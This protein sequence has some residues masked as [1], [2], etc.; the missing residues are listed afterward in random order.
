[1][2]NVSTCDAHG[3][4]L[5]HF[6]DMYGALDAEQRARLAGAERRTERELA[7]RCR[8]RAS[9]SRRDGSWRASLQGQ[10]L[11]RRRKAPCWMLRREDAVVDFAYL[12]RG[13][14]GLS[15]AHH[16]NSM[17]G[18]LGAA[19]VAGYFFGEDNAGLSPEVGDAIGGYLDRIIAGEEGLWFDA[20]GAGISVAELFTPV[21]PEESDPALTGSIAEALAGNIDG[22][23]QSG[24]N[25]IFAAIALRALDDH[26]M[27][28]TPTLIGGVRRLIEGFDAAAMGRGYYGA[29]RGWIEGAD[30]PV[31]DSVPAYD[32]PDD[33]AAVVVEELIASAAERK[34]GFGGPW[35][36]INHTAALIEL[37]A[38]GYGDL[39]QRGLAAHRK[40]VQLWRS[41]PD[42][43]DE[44]G[45]GVK[46]TLPPTGVEFWTTETPNGQS[47]F[48]THR[49][50]TQY[51]FGRVMSV[52]DDPATAREAADR[53][54]YLM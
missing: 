34:R 38:R 17:A 52:V 48:L 19:V 23:R 31:D 8:R 3:M 15:R 54:Q 28:A 51:G 30:V 39:A 12:Y 24:H 25:V 46:V 16:A 4:L 9:S 2:M 27:H 32:T 11:P 20:D 37:S 5:R 6:E 40:H 26:P 47:A 41:L 10:R 29:A 1:M 36:V 7:D 49:I 53:L 22:F 43:T 50:K 42:L 18:H 45:P 35:H 21:T 44:L 14:C 33:M 13:L